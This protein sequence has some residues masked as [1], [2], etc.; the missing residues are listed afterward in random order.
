MFHAALH[1]ALHPL[2]NLSPN[3]RH[4]KEFSSAARGCR[5]PGDRHDRHREEGGIHW[6]LLKIEGDYVKDSKWEETGSGR[7][8]SFPI[9]R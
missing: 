1:T 5:I 9:L 6:H 7:L 2:P 8:R 4:F 3:Y